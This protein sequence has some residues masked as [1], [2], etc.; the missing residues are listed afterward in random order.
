MNVQRGINSCISGRVGTIGA[1]WPR[2]HP[3]GA[4]L[5]LPLLLH[6]D[7]T[8][9][10]AGS[11]MTW[12]GGPINAYLRS[13]TATVVCSPVARVTCIAFPQAIRIRTPLSA[14]CLELMN[15]MQVPY[16]RA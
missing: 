8:R 14:R 5:A 1:R 2:C 7:V 12:V 11:F 10:Y 16:R 6:L 15:H 13:I 3:I 4:E 9:L